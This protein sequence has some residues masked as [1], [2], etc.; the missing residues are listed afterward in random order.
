MNPS[1]SNRVSR[2]HPRIQANFKYFVSCENKNFDGITHDVSPGGIAIFA[3]HDLPPAR[4]LEIKFFIPDVN[5]HIDAK[6]KVIYCIGN[7]YPSRQS[8][9]Y[10]IGLQF[11]EGVFEDL[12]AKN[13][14]GQVSR[15]TPAQTITI[16]A[17]A[18]RCYEL[19]GYFERYP[20][21]TLGVKQSRVLERYPDGRGK[22]V[23]F[24][25]NFFLSQINYTLNYSYDDE[26]N[27]LS[28]VSTE[29]SREILALAQSCIFVPKGKD[30]VFVTYEMDVTLS[31]VP[32]PSLIQYVTSILM[33]KE[34]YNFKKFIESNPK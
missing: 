9:K 28:S 31:F 21:W 20:E 2:A 7:P 18:K 12:F 32:S 25:H 4:E 26:K 6:G 22:R 11:A 30:S 8:T 16:N 24:L 34:M 13:T 3:D 29:T 27:L 14:R 19:L 10:L 15:H 23:E 1:L 33:R 17:P 5:L